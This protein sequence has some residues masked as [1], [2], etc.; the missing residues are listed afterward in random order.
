MASRVDI[1]ITTPVLKDCMGDLLEISQ[2]KRPRLYNII[3]KKEISNTRKLRIK[4]LS[5]R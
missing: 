4:I 1:V 3:W 2:R 5:P